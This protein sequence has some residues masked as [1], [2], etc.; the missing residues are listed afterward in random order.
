VARLE[1]ATIPQ[2]SWPMTVHLLEPSEPQV[3]MADSLIMALSWRLPTRL[4]GTIVDRGPT[5]HECEAIQPHLPLGIG[6]RGRGSRSGPL[7]SMKS[8]EFGGPGLPSR[9][10]K[11][12]LA[13]QKPRL[14]E[15]RG[16]LRGR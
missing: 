9:R 2:H 6:P 10:T 16:R 7:P 8:S 5:A 3:H 15:G 12:C 4:T 1:L 13:A 14:A 11:T